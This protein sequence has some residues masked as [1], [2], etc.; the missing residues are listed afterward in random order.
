MNFN[1][2]RV[3]IVAAKESFLVY[4]KGKPAMIKGISITGEEV[5][6][7]ITGLVNPTALDF[8]ANEQYIYF[9]DGNK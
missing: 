3:Y 4:G 8:D 6:Q 7:P 5:M 9:V 2:Y 1:F